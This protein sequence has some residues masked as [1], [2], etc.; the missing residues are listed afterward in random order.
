MYSLI[1]LAFFPAVST[2]IASTP[3]FAGISAVNDGKNYIRV[4]AAAKEVGWIWAT[5]VREDVT[6]PANLLRKAQARLGCVKCGNSA[7]TVLAPSFCYFLPSVQDVLY[8]YRITLAP[9]EIMLANR[10]HP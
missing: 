10:A 3:K 2:I 8:S 9:V 6:L 4:D 1:F 5:E 7:L